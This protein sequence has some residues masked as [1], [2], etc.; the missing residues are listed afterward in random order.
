MLISRG[1]KKGL[2]AGRATDLPS[3]GRGKK[4]SPPQDETRTECVS[5]Q[6][7]SKHSASTETATFVKMAA[8]FQE[9]SG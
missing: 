4:G 9:C 8:L 3:P 6:N 2:E 7:P 1:R 5:R